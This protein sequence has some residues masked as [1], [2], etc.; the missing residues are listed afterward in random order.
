[1]KSS[2]FCHYVKYCKSQIVNMMS[3]NI[4]KTCG[5]YLFHIPNNSFQEWGFIFRHRPCNFLPFQENTSIFIFCFLCQWR[6]WKPTIDFQQ[7]LFKIRS[8]FSSSTSWLIAKNVFKWQGCS[9]RNSY[10][11]PVTMPQQYYSLFYLILTTTAKYRYY[12]DHL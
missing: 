2:C 4:N 3:C 6:R 1:M 8:W 9:L 5:L 10:H 11:V 12:S 7:W